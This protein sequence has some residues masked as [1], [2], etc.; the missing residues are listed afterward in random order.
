MTRPS[1]GHREIAHTA[2]LGFE[3]WAE[4]LP[5]L[6]AES[7]HA[8]GD[9]CYDLDEVRPREARRLEI[10]GDNLEERMVRWLQEVYYVLESELWLTREVTDVVVADRVVSGTLR[11][12]PHDADRHTLHTEIKAI[13]YHRLD[14][15]QEDGSWRTTVIVDV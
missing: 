14:I 6:F 15:R 13:T 8:L 5:G 10:T 4:D 11:G 9:L 1:R 7:V 2:D 12:E 3:V